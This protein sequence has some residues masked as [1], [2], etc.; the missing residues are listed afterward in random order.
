MNAWVRFAGWVVLACGAA[1]VA[2]GATTQPA[3]TSRPVDARIYLDATINDKPVRLIVDTGASH[4]LLSRSCANRLNLKVTDP[5][6]GFRPRPGE[7]A[8]GKTETCIVRLG[9]LKRDCRLPVVDVPKALIGMANFEGVVGWP[10]IQ[11][12]IWEIRGSERRLSLL[13][14]L[15]KNISEWT[16]Y[17]LLKDSAV[18]AFRAASA[19][20]E[21]MAI[22]ID[23]GVADGIQLSEQQ[24]KKWRRENA[25]RPATMHAIWMP[26]TGITASEVCWAEKLAFASFS[27]ANVPVEQSP[28]IGQGTWKDYQASMGLF[29]LL[30]QD[31]IL[32]WPNGNMY[33]RASQSGQVCYDHNRIGAVF[34]PGGS[35]GHDLVAHVVDPSPAHEAGIRNGDVLL[36][37]DKLDVSKWQTD[38]S[39]LPLHRFWSR[40]PGT[41]TRLMLRREGKQFETTVELKDILQQKAD[42]KAVGRRG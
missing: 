6:T 12:N 7:V 10:V 41:R 1:A 8:V 11:E 32:D 4:F 13:K 40:Q 9:K 5:P 29:A 26:A 20:S 35:K 34:V 19:N 15:P 39:V 3:A 42:K 21:S 2:V 24:W 25:D 38:P 33:V 14:E 37:I 16:K 18:L 30:R 22:V 23:T 27:I 28:C 36:K 17:D 31:T